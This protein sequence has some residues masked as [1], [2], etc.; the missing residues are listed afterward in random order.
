M[1]LATGLQTRTDHL[2]EGGHSWLFQFF[3]VKAMD[4]GG[5]RSITLGPCLS[6]TLIGGGGISKL[7][8]QRGSV[9]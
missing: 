7:V 5:W 8:Q 2:V 3:P 6:F 9:S 1:V 4:Y